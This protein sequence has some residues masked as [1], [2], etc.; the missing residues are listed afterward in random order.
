MEEESLLDYNWASDVPS[1]PAIQTLCSCKMNIHRTQQGVG[2][3]SMD[4]SDP[5]GV[6]GLP[7]LSHTQ[8][9]SWTP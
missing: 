4:P 6:D 2:G 1:W 7:A 8:L 9:C 5:Q 3:L